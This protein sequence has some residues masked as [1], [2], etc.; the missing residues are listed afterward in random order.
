[1]RG[2]SVS[3]IAQK[4][5]DDE[6]ITML[7]AYDA[8][9]G[10]LVDEA[11]VDI[12]LVGDSMGNNHLGYSS[13]LPVTMEEVL[14]STGAVARSVDDA[15]VVADLPFLASGASME[16][17]VQNA[18]RL[19]KEAHADAVKLETPPGGTLTVDIVD[20]LVE[21]GVPVMGHVGFTPQH[22]KQFGGHVVQ[23]RGDAEATAKL[24]D[25][26]ERLE[27]AGAFAI[28][29]EAVTESAGA[30]VTEAVNVPTIGIGAGRDV[31]GQ[32]LVLND[33]I[34]LGSYDLTFNE[35]YAEVE[36][37]ISDA[38]AEFV[39]DVRTGAFPTADHAFTDSDE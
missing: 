12:V 23:G 33:V 39:S 17:S 34:G 24:V 14:V 18:G 5:A 15:L 9:M 28:V 30:L 26:A 32:V 38:L 20:R 27:S 13:T 3:D 21:L 37:V 25:T 2:T 6:P 4:E 8:Q 16:A 19:M 11:G 1:M 22:L 29:V 36:R 35:Q 31:D 10:R 7:T